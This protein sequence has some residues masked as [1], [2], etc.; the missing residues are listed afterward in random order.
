[1]M[2]PKRTRYSISTKK[3]SGELRSPMLSL[4]GNYLL[5]PKEKK[6]SVA[7]T[8]NEANQFQVNLL[9]CSIYCFY[10][11][12]VVNILKKKPARRSAEEIEY[13]ISGTESIKFFMDTNEEHGPETH[14]ECCRYMTYCHLN[15]QEM[16][17]EQGFWKKG[18]Y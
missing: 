18:K 9:N 1:M 12:I 10:L 6:V 7:F 5:K 16:L 2:L 15:K 13:L 3:L 11:Q 8:N 17:F 14:Q 4:S